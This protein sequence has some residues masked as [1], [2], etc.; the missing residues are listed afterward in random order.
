MRESD[1]GSEDGESV[2]GMNGWMD[3]G[4]EGEKGKNVNMRG[5]MG[6]CGGIIVVVVVLL[7]LTSSSKIYLVGGS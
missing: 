6:G 5:I 1:R 2:D 3:G 4:R 7:V